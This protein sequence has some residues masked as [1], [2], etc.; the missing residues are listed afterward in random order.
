[1]TRVN[2]TLDEKGEEEVEEE[3]EE[4]A[5]KERM[6]E[7]VKKEQSW[8]KSIAVNLF[9]VLPPKKLVIDRIAAPICTDLNLDAMG[10]FPLPEL[11][12]LLPDSYLFCSN[13]F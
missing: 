7:E 1:M 3:E 10:S 2:I 11:P 9:F 5:Q 8:I 4:R 6:E 12:E 13:F